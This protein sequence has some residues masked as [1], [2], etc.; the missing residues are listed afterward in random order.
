MNR[1]NERPIEFKDKRSLNFVPNMGGNTKTGEKWMA[2]HLFIATEE[3]PTQWSSIMLSEIE[4]SLLIRRKTN[5]LWNNKFL[6]TRDRNVGSI[7]SS[8]DSPSHR[9][10]KTNI[11]LTSKAMTNINTYWENVIKIH[12]IAKFLRLLLLCSL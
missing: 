7:D 3:H 2:F 4:N 11:R 5:L 12:F 10:F 1:H 8:A 6:K 9:L